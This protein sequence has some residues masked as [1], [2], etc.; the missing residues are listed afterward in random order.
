MPKWTSLINPKIRR[1]DT[2]TLGDAARPE[3]NLSTNKVL[4][5]ED[6]IQIQF[7]PGRIARAT[8]R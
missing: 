1:W 7:K 4:E 8:T 5:L 2:G 3:R 6:G